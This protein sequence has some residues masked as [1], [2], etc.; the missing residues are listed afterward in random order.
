MDK[1]KIIQAA[2]KF[3]QKGQFD[4]AIAEYR[5]ILKEDPKDVRILLKIGELQQK[6]GENDEAAAT[7]LEVARSYATDGFF[8]KAVAV[9]KQVLKLDPARVD[10]TLRLAELYQQL[11]LMSDAMAQLQAASA[12]YEKVGSIPESLEI[13]RRMVELEPDNLASRIRLADLHAR[14]EQTGEALKELRSAA[15]QLRDTSR[16]DDYLKVGERIVALDPKDL[17]LGR[18]L[19]HAWLAKNDARRALARLQV[20]FQQDP[21]NAE[22][23]ELLARS[24]VGLGQKAKAASVYKE[25][26]RAH[27]ERSRVDDERKAWAR[28]LEMAP[29]DTE[30]RQNLGLSAI[31]AI[32]HD[33]P[34]T[35]PPLGNPS[36]RATPPP[37]VPLTPAPPIAPAA[38]RAPTVQP[39]PGRAPAP[40]APAPR[41]A[42]SFA[43]VSP[44]PTM[45]AGRESIP[46]LLTETDV[47]VKYGLHEKAAEH[48]A[49]ILAIDPESI[50]AHEK[51]AAVYRGRSPAAQIA[52]LAALARLCTRSGE[53]ER[54]K[55]H[56]EELAH[57]QPGHPEVESLR[58][59][60]RGAAVDVADDAI[61]AEADGDADEV[62]AEPLLDDVPGALA[63]DSFA[64]AAL[65]DDEPLLLPYEPS[66]AQP[67]PVAAAADAAGWAPSIHDDDAILALAGAALGEEVI[68]EPLLEV[69]TVPR[70]PSTDR[71]DTRPAPQPLAPTVIG[72]AEDAPTTLDLGPL[73]E[74]MQVATLHETAPG[75]EPIYDETLEI[76]RAEKS[77]TIELL[78]VDPEPAHD[79]GAELEEAAFYVQQGLLDEAERIYRA[80]LAREPNHPDALARLGVLSAW[81]GAEPGEPLTEIQL[82]PTEGDEPITAEDAAAAVA[83]E[84]TALHEGI[85]RAPDP[86]DW[87]SHGPDTS[88]GWNPQTV[89]PPV[90][91]PE[92]SAS[93]DLVEDGTFDLG[94]ALAQELAE[95]DAQ[96]PPHQDFQY[97]ADEVLEEFKRGVAKSV[98]PEDAETHYNLAIAYK[99]MGLFP[100]AI[101][102]FATARTGYAG[103]PREI[104][105]VTMIA[106]CHRAQGHHG[107]AIA[108]LRDGLDAATSADARKALLFELALVHEA[109]G[110]KDDALAAFGSVARLDGSYRD[111]KG[112]IARLVAAGAV[113]R[114]VESRTTAGTP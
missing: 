74:T 105:C 109:A 67:S 35:P 56:W 77:V 60:Y 43:A 14:A 23:L 108:A 30:A 13:A 106:L 93:F 85:W 82:G 38:A 81:R 79:T 70:P 50:P 101:E 39:A 91:Q 32:S 84:P 27:R 34:A 53:I 110:Q 83:S 96:S 31:P 9:F 36:P 94:A 62:I 19:A 8:L 100:D 44:G 10:V 95:E 102:E 20:C 41:A 89:P 80:I 12:H 28:V 16:V 69:G 111:V 3:V 22:T 63:N 55:P 75:D 97:D 65:L 98:R 57:L 6:K 45:A 86:L 25:L 18:E 92:P 37:V 61:L 68:D 114:P 15:D 48:L 2:T 24:F 59:F 104:D 4:K 29:D 11:G 66:Q 99:E 112:A 33:R 87:A 64:D 47:F 51:A 52:S 21:K 1:N 88:V 103:T 26:A 107:E 7:L 49:K 73:A 42:E 90:P 71:F 17:D 113:P 58:P 72:P 54:G 78:E 5:R 76:P 46:R 40:P